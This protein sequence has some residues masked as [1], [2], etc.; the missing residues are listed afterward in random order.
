MK[1]IHVSIAAIASVG[2][3]ILFSPTA[4]DRSDRRHRLRAVIT[5][6]C[7]ERHGFN[8]GQSVVMPL[9]PACSRTK[10]NRCP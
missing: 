7:Y 3:L 10:R 9:Q 8:M 5:Q 4:A 2:A 1:K 6:T